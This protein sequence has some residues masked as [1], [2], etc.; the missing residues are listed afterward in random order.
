MDSES[1]MG[2]WGWVKA[3]KG[4]G[5]EKIGSFLGAGMSIV[6]M[7]LASILSASQNDQEM[8]LLDQINATGK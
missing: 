2:G 6:G 3:L 5:A 4:V 7:V 1:T 8:K